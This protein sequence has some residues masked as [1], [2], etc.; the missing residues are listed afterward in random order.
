LPFAS[1]LVS[2]GD[3]RAFAGVAAAAVENPHAFAIAI[4]IEASGRA[5]SAADQLL[6]PAFIEPVRIGAVPEL[7][8]AW[9]KPGA[10]D[11]TSIA[12]TAIPHARLKRTRMTI[13]PVETPN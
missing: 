10:A 8:V 7:S 1:N 6:C 9:V 13:L 2:G 3:V 4:D 12:A 5:V 11:K